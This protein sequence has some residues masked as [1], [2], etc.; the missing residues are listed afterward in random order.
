ME[1][2]R[3]N[4]LKALIDRDKTTGWLVGEINAA[5]GYHFDTGYLSKV[6]LGKKKSVPIISE[7]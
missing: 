5:T 3:K 6:L 4:V 1:E 7:C 2:F